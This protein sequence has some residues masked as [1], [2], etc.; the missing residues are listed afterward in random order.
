MNTNENWQLALGDAVKSSFRLNEQAGY[1]SLLKHLPRVQKT[2][3]IH[4]TQSPTAKDKYKGVNSSFSG[5]TFH[6]EVVLQTDG[7][8][9]I[10]SLL[11]AHLNNIHG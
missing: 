4:S 3:I 9:D 10:L 1:G 2:I 8:Y 6:L 11:L 5:N 7:T